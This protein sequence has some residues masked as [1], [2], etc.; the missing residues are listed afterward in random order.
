MSDISRESLE[1]YR[2][3]PWRWILIGQRMAED[4]SFEPGEMIQ[5]AI[6]ESDRPRILDPAEGRDALWGLLAQ[7]ERARGLRWLD[8]QGLLSELIPCWD[9]N[10]RRRRLRLNAVEEVHLEH[11]K[12]GLDEKVF[13]AICDNHD[14]HIDGRLDRWALTAFATL[15]AGGDTE[16]QASWAKMVR[17][18][19]HKLGASEA[20]IVWIESIVRDY[21]VGVQYLR[22][23]DVDV[24]MTPA[25]AICTLSTMRVGG[26]DNKDEVRIATDRVNQALSD[27]TNDLDN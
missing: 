5:D 18:D 7:P 21:R 22:G 2:K 14:V 23:F 9:G 25:L 15:L 19:L 6:G 4:P 20:E 12:E 13:K 26:E 8:K 17:R 24:K 10:G 3:E 16:N 1:L 27:E 11:W